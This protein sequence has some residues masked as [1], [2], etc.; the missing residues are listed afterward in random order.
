MCLLNVS[1]FNR[2]LLILQLHVKDL[3]KTIWYMYHHKKYQKV[4]KHVRSWMIKT[5]T[6]IV[7]KTV[8]LIR[9]FC[10]FTLLQVVL[11]RKTSR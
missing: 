9:K 5:V 11:S 3:N 1:D 2:S 8:P 6:N 10:A 7:E 4:N